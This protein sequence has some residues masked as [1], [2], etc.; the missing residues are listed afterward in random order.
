MVAKSKEHQEFAERLGA[1]MKLKGWEGRGAATRLAE[2]LGVTPSLAASYVRGERIP[3]GLTAL[4][5]PGIFGVAPDFFLAAAARGPG[6]ARVVE[7]RLLD[8]MAQIMAD[9]RRVYGEGADKISQ[10][11]LEDLE[12]AER[13]MQGARTRRAR[14][15]KGKNRPGA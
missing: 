7:T 3:D 4:R 15:R 6:R 1:A 2:A 14:Q 8:E 10:Q 5:L 11:A 9:L 12:T 13:R